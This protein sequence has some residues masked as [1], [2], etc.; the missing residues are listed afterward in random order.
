[1]NIGR[2]L[3]WQISNEL[4]D[5]LRIKNYNS[6]HRSIPEYV[7]DLAYDLAWAISID[8]IYS[9]IHENTNK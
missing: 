6:V 5:S 2:Q 7:S 9:Y 1:M 4:C 8:I 3:K